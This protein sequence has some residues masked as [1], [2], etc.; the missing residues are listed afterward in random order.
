MIPW[1]M[2]ACREPVEPEPTVS[3]TV[4]EDTTP[5]TTPTSPPPPPPPGPVAESR[6]ATS[7][8]TDGCSVNGRVQPRGKPGTVWFEYGPTDA[9]GSTTPIEP[10]GPR[11]SAHYVERWDEGTGSWKGGFADD[12]SWVPTGGVSEGFVRYTEPTS[13]DYNHIDG[14]GE[15]HLVQ[16][17][18]P[19]RYE[20]P[21]YNVSAYLGGGDTD[22]RDA[23]ISVSVRGNGWARRHLAGIPNSGEEFARGDELVWWTQADAT[24]YR[25]LSQ[26]S[27]W[28]YTGFRLTDALY[29]GDW[30]PV[31]YTLLNDTREWSYAGQSRAQMRDVY[32]YHPIG[33]IQRHADVNVFHNLLFVDYRYALESQIDFD[34]LDITYRNHNVLA[35]SNGGSLV[36]APKGADPSPLTDGYRFGDGH[37]WQSET[38]EGPLTFD[39]SLAVPVTVHTV[40][41]HNDPE[42]PSADVEI[43]TSPDGVDWTLLTSGRLPR[44]SPHGSNF[45]FWRETGLSV[46]TSWLRVVVLRGW[47]DG[48]RGLGEIEVFGDGAVMETDDDWAYV[49][50]DLAGLT[51]GETVHYRLVAEVGGEVVY[52]EDRTFAVPTGE[53]PEMEIEAPEL[54]D[55]THLRVSARLNTLGTTSGTYWFEVG[56]DEDYGLSSYPTFTGPEITPRRFSRILDLTHNDLAGVVAGG[57]LA[58][59][60]VYCEGCDTA[61]PEDDVTWTSPGVVFTLP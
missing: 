59:R 17:F 61:E 7:L 16:Y 53:A 27:N 37:T 60:L 9:Y 36:A 21:N 2:M 50:A 38:A 3:D 54:V 56:A 31:T 49:T 15:L 23:V 26:M 1:L 48:A 43:Y 10:I 42:H 40:Q 8:G 45:L 35:A 29:S 11:R 47:E 22:L 41:V 25:D 34:E 4:T 46:E 14:I 51:P 24:E 28:A 13:I 18:Y 5:A 12:L 44:T 32:V 57:E 52:G 20:I 6:L 30:T 58:A 55:D 19:G 39:F 33:S